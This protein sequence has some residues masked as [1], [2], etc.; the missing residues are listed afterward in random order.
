MTYTRSLLTAAAMAAPLAAIG[1]GAQAADV[2]GTLKDQQQFST[3]S[4][5][6]ELAGIAATLQSGGPFTI[7]APT[8]DA[9]AQLPQGAGD[10]LMQPAN[11]DQLKT[12]VQYHVVEGQQLTPEDVAGKQTELDT[13]AGDRLSVDGTG[14]MLM[15]VPAGLSAPAPADQGSAQAPT[16][17]TAQGDMPASAH[18]EQVLKDQ[19]ATEQHQTSGQ[20]EGAMPASPHQQQ[21]L[22]DQPA[23]QGGAPAQAEAAA[24]GSP[25]TSGDQQP[26]QTEVTAQGDMPASAHQEQ[27]L[28][29]QPATEQR[30]TAGQTEG[31][32]PASPHQQQVLKDQQQEGQAAQ[33][34][35]VL[36]EATVIAEP[37]QADNGVIY[38]IDAVLVP[39]KILSQ[40]EG[41]N[42][43]AK[44]N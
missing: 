24:Q 29:E 22:K 5:A 32:M 39:Q 17:V 14:S 31:A 41:Q 36:R 15:L 6:I 1:F 30:Q 19:P 20:T 3:L 18:Q 27:V 38:A 42:G 37:I 12:L 11:Q 25:S 34:Q 21:V 10:Y 44:S 23:E 13:V 9:F 7:F 35:D 8:D 16:E 28:S 26:A 2:I 40:L 43:Q 4:K 33:A